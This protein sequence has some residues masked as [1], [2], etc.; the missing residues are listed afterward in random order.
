MGQGKPLLV[1]RME[2]ESTAGAGLDQEVALAPSPGAVASPG[3][4]GAGMGCSQAAFSLLLHTRRCSRVL[5][6]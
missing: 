2:E 6:L 4:L 5:L 3:V 1:E